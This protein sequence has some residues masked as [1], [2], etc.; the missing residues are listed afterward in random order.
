MATYTNIPASSTTLNSATYTNIPSSSSFA[1][2]DI[3]NLSLW[4]KADSIAG[5]D[6]DPISSWSDSSGNGNN[7]TQ[8]TGVSQ[9]LLKTAGNGLN[10]L[11]VVRFDG[12]N[13]FMLATFA[14]GSVGMTIFY[15]ARTGAA[16][17]AYGSVI[18]SGGSLTPTT[19]IRWAFDL[20]SAVDGFGAGWGGVA[21]AT[22]LGNVTGIA[23]STAFYARYRTDK[24]AWAIDG[25]NTGTPA[26][27]SFPTD[28]FQCNIG[29]EGTSG[30]GSFSFNGDVGEILIY[31]RD[32]ATDEMASVKD[33]MITRWGV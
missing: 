33:Y 24:T 21:G 12:S 16:L 17:T 14:P 31:V 10:G 1:P 29:R 18:G 30:G 8:A 19:G 3:A 5:S 26:D 9:P 15:V 23:T 2:T 27:T 25:V 6:G 7:A 32:L 11:N 28:T 20:G 22:G 13:D 4:L